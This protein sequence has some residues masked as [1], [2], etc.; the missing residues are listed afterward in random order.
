MD[1]SDLRNSLSYKDNVDITAK[2]LA[3]EGGCVD[4]DVNLAADILQRHRNST[5]QDSK[6]LCLILSAVLET[7]EQ[8]KIQPTPA[9][10]FASLV[11]TLQKKEA[12]GVSASV[13]IALSMIMPQVPVAIMR[14]KCIECSK[15]F[16]DII[17]SHADS[18]KLAKPA[19]GCL[20]QAVAATGPTDWTALSPSFHLL[21]GRLLD[22]HPKVR[23]K[24]QS[25]VVSV[26]AA[27]QDPLLSPCLADASK[28]LL[29]FTKNVLGAPEKAAQQAANSSNKE[30][31]KAEEVIQSAVSDSLRL[32]A[33]LRQIIHLIPGMVFVEVL[34]RIRGSVTR[35][36]DKVY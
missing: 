34:I 21:L 13:C 26:F 31:R 9:A 16:F 8:S 36:N 30:R 28:D 23:K 11:S 15:I 3:G 7:L 20:A 5:Q 35:W 32:M 18:P 10:L 25:G 12:V 33:C 6:Q 2:V 24:A 17:N 19:L 14:K 22:P 1:L 27:L 29:I 4:A